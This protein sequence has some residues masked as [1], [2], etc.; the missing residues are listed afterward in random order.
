MTIVRQGSEHVNL[1]YFVDQLG[2]KRS[3]SS[4]EG[5]QQVTLTGQVD[6]TLLAEIA[7]IEQLHADLSRLPGVLR[8]SGALFNVL[9]ASPKP[10]PASPPSALIGGRSP[11]R[12]PAR[13]PNSTPLSSQSAPSRSP[14]AAAP[15]VSPV[16]ISTPHLRLDLL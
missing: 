5:P 14:K 10:A 16:K 1:E 7:E 6:L 13:S 15:Q 3:T 11:A 8:V 4:K 2:D 12:S 9:Q